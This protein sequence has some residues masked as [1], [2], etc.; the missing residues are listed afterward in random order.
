MRIKAVTID[1][2]NTL[3]DNSNG[4][5]RNA[6]RQKALISEI[7]KYGLVIKQDEF[8][9]AMSASWEYFNKIWKN[10]SR[11]PMPIDT[12]TFFWNYL[13]LPDDK[14]AIDSIVKVFGE[15]ILDHP[16]ALMPGVEEALKK[17]SS[18]FKLGLV[19]DTGFSPGIVLRQLLKNVGIYDAFSSFSFSD[20]TMVSKP[21]EKAFNKVLNEL[22]IEPANAIHIGDIEDTDIRGAKNLGMLAIRFTG[23][24]SAALTINNSPETLADMRADNWEEIVKGIYDLN[25]E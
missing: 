1:F 25:F 2:W 10:E 22:Q 15:S 7:D 16:P 18:D 3:F 13:K 21:H 11:T 17:L 14:A 9:G 24:P 20:E 23:D 6:I 19:S 5:Q 8:A 12:A 4:I